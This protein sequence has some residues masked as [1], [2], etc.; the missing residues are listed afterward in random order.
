MEYHLRV[1][2]TKQQSEVFSK[3]F[4]TKFKLDIYCVSFEIAKITQ[5]Q[6]IHMYLKFDLNHIPKKST[7]SDFMK[8][9]G[10]SKKY[11]FQKQK[12]S[13]MKY[14]LY[15]LKDLEPILS[16]LEPE[17]LE[18]LMERCMDIKLDKKL[19]IKQ[20]YYNYWLDKITLTTE[21]IDVKTN[22]TIINQRMDYHIISSDFYIFN[23]I[24][25]YVFLN[26]LLPPNKFQIHQY[27][28][29]IK[30]QIINTHTDLVKGCDIDKKHLIFSS[31][32]SYNIYISDDVKKSMKNGN[33]E[34]DQYYLL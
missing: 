32:A 25:E 29:Y 10:Y 1:D 17:L 3:K 24:M 11:S 13:T 6:H 5:K 28:Q 4:I 12:K 7:L 22:I 16:N 34:C 21:T 20:K 27:I 18:E 2:T 31:A 30:L 8:K 33:I 9:E 26:D 19:T 14:L 15:I 23:C